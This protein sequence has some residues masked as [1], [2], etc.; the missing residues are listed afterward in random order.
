MTSVEPTVATSEPPA[1]EERGT[2][3]RASAATQPF[4]PVLGLLVILVVFLSITQS[5]FATR[6]NV[7]NLLSAVSVLWIIS[8]G[9]TL[10]LISGGFDLSAGAVAAVG[11]YTMAKLLEAGVPGGAT[12]ALT[13]GLGILVGGLANGFL[14]G[15]L[16]LN[17]FVVTLASMTSLAG[18]LSLWSGANSIY[19]T[20]PLANHLAIDKPAGVPTPIWIMAA[21][22]V[23]ALYVQER[24]YF[25]RD[26]FAVGGSY[27]AARL[28]GIRTTR[29]LIVIYA[30]LGGCATLAGAIATSR[31]GAATPLPD[32]TLPLQ[33]IAAV[34]LGG[35]ALTG[36]AGS[37][38]G[39]AFGVI[40]IGV[41]QNGLDI[42]GV[43]GAWQQVLTGVILVAAVLAGRSDAR[44][45][46]RRLIAARRDR[47]DTTASG[48]Q[49]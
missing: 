48:A 27:T 1:R 36:G 22:F 20:A 32:N 30:A 35:T 10:V 8:M 6:G 11:G 37:V 47:D 25:G 23:I 40:F 34:L 9:M 33:A 4:R 41:L 46:V 38:W 14:I 7:E 29:T 16:R 42:S 5:D 18:I 39:T 13:V 43:A 26:I 2:A 31:A 24:T 12:I 45:S 17:V 28:S 21:V 3:A 44:S 15:R 19:V 49:P